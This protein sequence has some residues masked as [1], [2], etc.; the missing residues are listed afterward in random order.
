MKRRIQRKSLIEYGLELFGWGL[1]VVHLY[2]TLAFKTIPGLSLS[3][4][5]WAFWG[6]WIACILIALFMTPKANRS[7]FCVFASINTPIAIYLI[8]SYFRIYRTAFTIGLSVIGAALVAYTSLVLVINI[9]DVWRGKYRGRLTKFFAYFLHAIRMVASLGLSILFL[10]F[11]LNLYFGG[12]LMDPI[13]LATDPKVNNQKISGNIETI[14]LLQEDEWEKLSVQERLD[15]LQTVA[16]IE[17]TYLGLPHELNVVVA[18]TD[19]TTSGHYNDRTHTIT[20][21]PDYIA[22]ESAHD[23]VETIAHEAFHAYEHR[24]V[25]LHNSVS[26]QE[27]NLL[28]FDRISEYKDNFE[29]YIDG[30]DDIY[31]YI[32]QAVETD[33]IKYAMVAVVDY[34]TAIE[35]YV[36][37]GNG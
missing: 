30:D 16:N 33:S 5:N 32:T 9:G 1:V 2:R 17:A 22:D 11:Y 34:Y 20:I 3:Q 26:S 7:S 13:T 23:L 14:L 37:E 25:D 12:P 31:G 28:I 6:I 24:L 21:N 29:N 36:E 19:E 27:R 18:V 4:S 15:V 35:D 10:V 8:L